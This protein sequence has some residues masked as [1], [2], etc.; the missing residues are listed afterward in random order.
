M[1]GGAGRGMKRRS[2]A[3]FCSGTLAAFFFSCCFASAT[4]C[5]EDSLRVRPHASEPA[6]H[7]T[8][9]WFAAQ[10][11]PS[12]QWTAVAHDRLCFGLRWQVTPL[13]YSFGINRKLSPWRWFIVE[14]FVRQSGSVEI[15]FSPEYMNLKDQYGSRWAFRTGLRGYVPLWQHGEYLSGSIGSSYFALG[16]TRG[17]SYEAGVYFFAGIVGVQTTYSPL[18]SEAPWTFTLRLRYF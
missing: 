3:R 10:V 4:H 9:L 12:P 2:P 7:P 18:L 15:F 13:L 8:I 1:D 5:G 11:V 6:I 17:M 16:D 14:P